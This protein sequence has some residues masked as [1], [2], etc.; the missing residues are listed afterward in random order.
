[1]GNLLRR[2]LVLFLE[3]SPQL[4]DKILGLFPLH[5]LQLGSLLPV[6]FPQVLSIP[7]EHLEKYLGLWIHLHLVSCT[8]YPC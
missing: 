5:S 4:P 1:M 7:L 6:R 2:L 8:V 3:G